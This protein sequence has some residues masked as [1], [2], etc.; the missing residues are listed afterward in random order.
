MKDKPILGRITIEEVVERTGIPE[1][2]FYISLL[3]SPAYLTTREGTSCI[4]NMIIEW[5]QLDE[6]SGIVY[7]NVRFDES[8][9]AI[10]YI[11]VVY[12]TEQK[13]WRSIPKSEWM[14]KKETKDKG[15][16]NDCI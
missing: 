5:I 4:M 9:E 8:P 3:G 10:H 2:K 13:T 15:R 16:A 11:K 1:D 6:E 12:D 7:G 14:I